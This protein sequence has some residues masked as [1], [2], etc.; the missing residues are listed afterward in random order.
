M[1]DGAHQW[2]RMLMENGGCCVSTTWWAYADLS[3]SQEEIQT[4]IRRTNKYSISKGEEDYKI[5]LYDASYDHIEEV[6]NELHKMHRLVSGRE[7]RSQASW[8]EQ[9]KGVEQ[10]S[11][12][13][14]YDFV[15]FIRD[16]VTNELAG[17]AL[18]STTPQ[19][20]LYCVA[21]YDRSRFRKP[22]GHI[23]QAV[24]MDYMRKR[25][26]R[27]Y[28]V[29]ERTYPEYANGDEK[30]IHIGDYKEGFATHIFPKLRIELDVT[31]LNF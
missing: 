27:W 12:Q 5:E 4:R 17:G 7:T 2:P 21:A 15:I 19:T 20:G 29:G 31:K 18:F 10:G 8:D 24:A 6:V 25:G 30:L 23:V 3:L 28:E 13:T 1:D 16:K 26:V 22:T 9:K 11:D 14:G